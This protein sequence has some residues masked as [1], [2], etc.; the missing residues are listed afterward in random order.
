MASIQELDVSRL[1]FD[2]KRCAELID[3]V[4]GWLDASEIANCV[5][6]GITEQFDCTFARIWLIE[7]DRSKLKLVASAGLYTRL[8]GSFASVPMGSFKVGKIAQHCIPFLSN[9]LPEEAWVKD[10]NWA[11]ANN[12]K[13]FAGLPL[14]SEDRA[15]GVLALFSHSR[16]SPEFLEVL[17]MLSAA[18]AGALASALK[19]EAILYERGLAIAA[20][21]QTA[22]QPAILSEQLAI[23]LGH[24]KLSLLGTEQPLPPA[25]AQLFIQ[26]ATRLNTMPCQYCRLV[27]ETEAVVLE[28]MLATSEPTLEAEAIT[29][30]F[31]GIQNTAQALKGHLSLQIDEEQAMGK[32]RLQLPPM[33]AP[34]ERENSL[35]ASPLS[36][37]SL[38]ASPLSGREQEVIQLLALGLRDR[39]IAEKLYI[40]ERTVKFHIKNMLEK[41]N[42]KTR[43]Q[44]T[45]QAVRQGWLH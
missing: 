34:N 15:I 37:S 13:G 12:I 43:A 40:S 28:A 23:I 26:A 24:R 27:Y 4:S 8:D 22:H 20:T 41:L 30:A 31:Q 25:I 38:S 29:S 36:A 10:R 44:A 2:L 14:M 3:R 17:Q 45:C 32:I 42:V 19:H 39:E 1:L 11:I 6:V 9:C 18:I 16:I 5:T 33:P 21:C 35:S 7:P